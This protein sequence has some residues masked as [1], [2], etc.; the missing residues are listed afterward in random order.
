MQQALACDAR[1]R[2]RSRAMRA[3]GSGR[4]AMEDAS[5]SRAARTSARRADVAGRHEHQLLLMRPAEVV[6]SVPC[7]I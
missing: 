2:S 6:G 4:L 3:G 1:V 5:R 7:A